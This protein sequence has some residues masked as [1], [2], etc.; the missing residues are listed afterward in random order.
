MVEQYQHQHNKLGMRS[1]PSTRP[2]PSLTDKVSQRWNPGSASATL[3]KA[4]ASETQSESSNTESITTAMATNPSA[5]NDTFVSEGSVRDR[6]AKFGTPSSRTLSVEPTKNKKTILAPAAPMPSSS[7]HSQKSAGSSVNSKDIMEEITGGSSHKDR[8]FAW[9]KAT[10]ISRSSGHGGVATNDGDQDDA[11]AM[12]PPPS[13]K[14]TSTATHG[15]ASFASRGSVGGAAAAKKAALPMQPKGSS[16]PVPTDMPKGGL[17]VR[18]RMKSWGKTTPLA[19]KEPV[20]PAPS[21]Q[22]KRPE[23]AVSSPLPVHSLP[24]TASTDTQDSGSKKSH[25][26]DD[27]SAATSPA[28][29]SQSLATP[30]KSPAPSYANRTLKKVTPPMEDKHKHQK[31]AFVGSTLP[32]VGLKKVARPLED[33]HKVH[34]FT[35][36]STLPK[37]G[38]KKVTLLETKNEQDVAPPKGRPSL[39]SAQ[40]LRSVAKPRDDKWK[41]SKESRPS[42]YSAQSLRN[43]ERPKEGPLEK[44]DSADDGQDSEHARPVVALKSVGVPSEAKWKQGKEQY[45]GESNEDSAAALF[46]PTKLRSVAPPTEKKPSQVEVPAVPLYS[47]SMLRQATHPRDNKLS[48]VS[49]ETASGPLYSADFLR[50]VE[51]P[52]EGRWKELRTVG[53]DEKASDAAATATTAEITTPQP[54][55]ATPQKE[56]STKNDCATGNV[57]FMATVQEPVATSP[58]PLPN[59][60]TGEKTEE[61][62]PV[63]PVT[64]APVEAQLS[65]RDELTL[66]DLVLESPVN[67]PKVPPSPLEQIVKQN[68]E[69]SS[70][71]LLMLVSSMSGRQ[72][73]KT[74]QDRALT[75][76]KGMHIGD[77]QMEVLD[78]A[79]SLN[80]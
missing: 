73:Q 27:G 64:P 5:K 6:L 62:S 50:Q 59:M 75:I 25:A 35:G 49:D 31:E 77:D 57:H 65:E 80:V 16:S 45:D 11:K 76:L 18:D 26:T 58:S 3:A 7:T 21:K 74:A 71:K 14:K 1:T 12:P 19:S 47:A 53:T 56:A 72:D 37:V 39:Y 33:K 29:S 52:N 10:T 46:S 20:S 28:S 55:H 48:T 2:R 68:V 13:K 78:G 79:V 24:P 30:N 60:P 15:R 61:K 67:V 9:G 38:L 42:L 69:G 43:V 17:S 54:E 23:V 51:K 70:N 41:E 8:M 36:T 63:A 44:N 32:T 4:A 40:S 34:K 66:D 22:T